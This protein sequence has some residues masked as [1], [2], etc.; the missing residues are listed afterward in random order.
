MATAF[1][2]LKAAMAAQAAGQPPLWSDL[3][4]E[5]FPAISRP[6]TW[7]AE[8]LLL[9]VLRFERRLRLT[10]SSDLPHSMPPE[11]MLKSL[12]IQAL[13][14]W[15]GLAYLQEME[16]VQATTQSS[17]LSSLVRDVIQKTREEAKPREAKDEVGVSG[18]EEVMKS[19]PRRLGM[20]RGMSYVPGVRVR[21]G[22]RER[23]LA[24]Y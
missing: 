18:P 24:S 2:T 16:R 10:V 22:P 13:G 6:L 8:G 7:E 19:V 20:E 23:E 14:R 17:S 15:T 4:A 1:R 21:G 9:G 3:M 11:D 5:L 12:A